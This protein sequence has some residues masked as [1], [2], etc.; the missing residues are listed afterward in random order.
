MTACWDGEKWEVFNSW[1]QHMDSYEIDALTVTPD[2]ILWA[3]GDGDSGLLAYWNGS[4]WVSCERW[5]CRAHE[6]KMVQEVHNLLESYLYSSAPENPR[7]VYDEIDD[8][9]VAPDGSI[10]AAV[11]GND[12]ARWVYEVEK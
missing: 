8:L 11:Y 2:G 4:K 12:I 6:K 1:P 7:Y 10:W 3:G 5:F 9:T